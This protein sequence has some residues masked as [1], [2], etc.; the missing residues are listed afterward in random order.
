L[1]TLSV[2]W[3][4]NVTPCA[5]SYPIATNSQGLAQE[6]TRLPTFFT[7]A[8]PREYSAEALAAALRQK[9]TL[10]EMALVVNPLATTTQMEDAAQEM[11]AGATKDLEKASKL[12]AR[13]LRRLPD[14]PPRAHRTRTAQEVFSAWNKPGAC[15]SCMEL[16]YLY[17]AL[18]RATGMKAHC[19]WVEENCEGRKDAHSCAAVFLSG[20]S[21]LAD[22]TYEWFGAP[23]KRFVVLD[24]V[25][26]AGVQLASFG[27]LQSCQAA[28][29]LAPDLI[30]VRGGVFHGLAVEGRWQEARAQLAVMMRL[31]P[32]APE[33]LESRA[34]L[35]FH[36]RKL[37][38]E[39]QLLCRAI[40]MAPHTG[41]LHAMLGSA[42]VQQGKL[43]EARAAFEKALRY[44]MDE[45][46]AEMSKQTLAWI[47]DQTEH[48][49]AGR[50][51]HSS[52]K[53][54]SDE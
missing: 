13:L 4:C 3:P 24:D 2:L 29:K 31:A 23:H 25:Q 52:S 11:T 5:P 9:L 17:V 35:A 7:N 1:I 21:L 37:D 44:P 49:E 50:Q 8:P 28:C 34:G 39:I 19:V 6:R 54:S 16:T 10:K 38:E 12:F 36:E 47:K 53:P 27:N 15:F 42:Y 18:A 45:E 14:E 20:K 48:A 41:P 22:L 26:T 33:T 40:E 46:R 51:Q 43:R 32:D 30:F